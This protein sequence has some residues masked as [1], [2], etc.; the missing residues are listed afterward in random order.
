MRIQKCI[1][2][3]FVAQL[4]LSPTKSYLQ[5]LSLIEPQAGGDKTEHQQETFLNN[6]PSE[7]DL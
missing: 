3:V 1:F 7:R 6:F 2:R 4:S 5:F